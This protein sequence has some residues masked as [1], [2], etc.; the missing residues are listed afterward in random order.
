VLYVLT[1]LGGL[2]ALGLMTLPAGPA[3]GLVALYVSLLGVVGIYLGQVQVTRDPL[4]YASPLPSEVTNRYRAYEVL[5]DALLLCAAYYLAFV[6]RF[7][8]EE[9]ERFLPYFTRS[10]PFVVGIQLVALWLSGKYRQVWG[11]VGPSEMARL[12]RASLLG[13]AASVVA[14]VYLERFDGYSRFV[15]LFDAILA[16]VFIVSARSAL[17]G[18]DQYLRL[19]RSRGRTALIYGAG[20]S[21]T[22]TMREMLQNP[23]LGL[24]PL[25]FID[26]DPKK[27][28]LRIEGLAVVGTVEDLGR[29]LDRRPGAVSAV[30]IAIS[31][32]SRDRLDRVVAMCTERG[33]A[34]RRL[35]LDLEEVRSQ[36]AASIVRFPGA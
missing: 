26:D 34:I 27:R 8:A 23:S 28:R 18:L 20:R 24:T 21:G 15:F 14:M 4:P 29:L 7:R 36:Q 32:L 6:A 10:I 12:V 22:I 19:R 11:T 17:S 31:D 16:P 1:G 2:V 9:F 33:I 5:V 30:I 35:R 25:G 3:W 13:V